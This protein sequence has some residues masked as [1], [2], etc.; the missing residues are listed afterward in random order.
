MQDPVR[1]PGL[2]EPQG[3]GRTLRSLGAEVVCARRFPDHHRYVARDLFEV[4]EAA[5]AAGA[6]LLITTEKDAVKLEDLPAPELPLHC[7]AIEACV[8]RGEDLVWAEIGRALSAF[9][10]D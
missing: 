1:R 8:E 6:E 9:P 5:A 2:A 4:A 10:R 7:L 3:F